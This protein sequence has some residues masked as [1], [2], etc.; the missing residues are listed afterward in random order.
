MI[1]EITDKASG[2]YITLYENPD[3]YYNGKIKHFINKSGEIRTDKLDLFHQY[4]EPKDIKVLKQI[5][6]AIDKEIKTDRLFVKQEI[7]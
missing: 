6:I 2:I 5:L 1:F 4:L 7:V 3:P